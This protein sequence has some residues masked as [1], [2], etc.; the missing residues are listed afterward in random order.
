MAHRIAEVRGIIGG[1][2]TLLKK[3]IAAGLPTQDAEGALRTYVSSLEHLLS[4]ELKMREENE[5]KKGERRKLKFK[6]RV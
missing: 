4:H 5:I 3:L 2:Q 1:Q 6:R